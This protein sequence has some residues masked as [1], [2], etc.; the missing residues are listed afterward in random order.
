MEKQMDGLK[1]SE[2]TTHR[3][4]TD[5]VDAIGH[6]P[7]VYLNNVTN[8]LHA[9]I[10]VKLEYMNP[11]ASVK[12]RPGSY[13]IKIAEEKGM[14]TPGKSVLI[15]G[16]SLYIRITLHPDH[17]TSDHNTSESLYIRPSQC[18]TK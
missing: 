11:G 14:I 1:V 10:A 12:D 2:D 6:T 18:P 17:F 16:A 5:I 3:I 9:Q 7:L 8:G 15:E 4:C 13:M